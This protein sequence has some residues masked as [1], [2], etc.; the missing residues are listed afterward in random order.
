M[1]SKA[2]AGILGFIGLTDLTPIFIE[3]TLAAPDQ[4]DTTVAKAKEQAVA[5][6]KGWLEQ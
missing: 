2:L 5:V 3:P 1:Q 4:V 6:A